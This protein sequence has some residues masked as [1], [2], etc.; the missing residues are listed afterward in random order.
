MKGAEIMY[1]A[2]IFGKDENGE[3]VLIGVADL[4]AK[5]FISIESEERLENLRKSILKR[6]ETT[7]NEMLRRNPDIPFVYK[8]EEPYETA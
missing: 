3:P 6:L 1:M 7:A 8:D 5:K 4:K 2:R